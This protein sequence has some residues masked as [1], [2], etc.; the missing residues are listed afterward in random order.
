MSTDFQ[1]REAMHA[2]KRLETRGQHEAAAQRYLMAGAP[3]EAA[4]MLAVLGRFGQAAETLLRTLSVAPREVGTLDASGRRRAYLAASYLARAGE[5]ERAVELLLGLGERLKAADLVEQA[6]DLVRAAKLRTEQGTRRPGYGHEPG[7]RPEREQETAANP[8]AAA[9][10]EQDGRLEAAAQA[11]LQLGRHKDAGRVLRALGRRLEA[12]KVLASADLDYE[13]A[14]CLMEEGETRRALEH[15]VRVPVTH[16]HYRNAVSQAIDA[17]EKT[18]ELTF[19]FDAFVRPFVESGPQFEH[20]LELFHR[21]SLLYEQHKMFEEAIEVGRRLILKRPGYRNTEARLAQLESAGQLGVEAYQ[22]I[23]AQEDSFLGGASQRTPHPDALGPAR[24][25]PPTPSDLGRLPG[26]P[27]LPDLPMLKK[28]ATAVVAMPQMRGLTPSPAD[29]APPS[30]GAASPTAATL[31]VGAV[32]NDRYR[33]EGVLGQGGM[34]VVFKAMDLE[35]DELVAIKVFTQPVVDE[36]ALG[37]LLQ[38]FKQELKLSRKMRHKNIIQLYDFGAYHG[39]RYISMELLRGAPLDDVIETG[40]DLDQ[41]LDILIQACAGLQ[42]AHDM[43]VVHRDIKPD[44]LFLTTE[45]VVKVMD[46]GIAKKQSAPGVTVTGMVIGTP[47]YMSPEQIK[48]GSAVTP[49]ADLYSLGC[50][51]YKMFTGSQPFFHDEIV[52]L[53]MAHIGDTPAPLRELNTHVPAALEAVVLKLLEKDPE[54]R[55]PSA[56]ALA[57]HLR[58][59]RESFAA[60]RP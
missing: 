46:F 35:L 57:A 5:R 20:E 48:N 8:E 60:T 44:N 32:I 43:G 12:A 3:Q 11:W 29:Q 31:S 54:A 22:A 28:D 6:G 18:G 2:A 21:L 25:E 33:I 53:L 37:E 58:Q 27:E 49:A 42:A 26:L 1:K 24:Q 40:V 7:R 51:A 47:A 39:H 36:K 55:Y 15:L 56:S 41:G 10:A 14:Y 4:R 23:K 9:K 38:R 34:A 13:A 16:L 52:P 17:S 30:G 50:L 45:G 19:R 59:L